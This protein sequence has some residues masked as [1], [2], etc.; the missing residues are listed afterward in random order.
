MKT[1]QDIQTEAVILKNTQMGFLGTAKNQSHQLLDKAVKL[2]KKAGE[3]HKHLEI[4]D[5]TVSHFLDTR[6]GR[7]IAEML[8]TKQDEATVIASIKKHLDA[9]S[10]AY[11]PQAFESAAMNTVMAIAAQRRIE[12]L[13][14]SDGPGK[15]GIFSSNPL[16]RDKAV[17]AVRKLLRQPLKAHEAHEKLIKH[18][19]DDH[20]FKQIHHFKEKDPHVDVRPLVKKRMRELGHHVG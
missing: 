10:R 19:H 17:G 3:G 13:D 4:T 11:Q 16:R 7:H 2:V 1:F 5:V 20:L 14:E 15:G 6:A 18:A 9:F 12:A 8:L